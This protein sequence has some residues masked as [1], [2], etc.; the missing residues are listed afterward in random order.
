MDACLDSLASKLVSE[1]PWPA[2]ADGLLAALD[3]PMLVD[4]MGRMGTAAAQ[5]ALAGQPGRPA[6]AAAATAEADRQLLT[7]AQSS[8]PVYS[9]SADA[10]A[11]T[12]AFEVE[13]P[14][15]EQ[16]MPVGHCTFL[17]AGFE[18]EVNFRSSAVQGYSPTHGALGFDLQRAASRCIAAARPVGK[19]CHCG[20]DLLHARMPLCRH[21]GQPCSLLLLAVQVAA[22]ITVYG[23]KQYNQ[24]VSFSFLCS[25]PS[26]GRSL[27]LTSNGGRSHQ[28]KACA[29][30]R[31]AGAQP[32]NLRARFDISELMRA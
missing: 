2:G 23:M 6:A 19:E 16:L 31:V 13:V 14:S 18:W 26:H 1:R 29:A 7:T 12:C 15:F 24:L 32:V 25:V 5:R 27:C 22:Y 9:L 21:D 20:C 30:I 4:V 28:N 8:L 11:G 3:K 17:L 10:G